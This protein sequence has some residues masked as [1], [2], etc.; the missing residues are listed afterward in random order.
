MMRSN[1]QK[2]IIFFFTLFLYHTNGKAEDLLKEAQTFAH[3]R[4]NYTSNEIQFRI[5]AAI[6]ELSK[7]TYFPRFI[8]INHYIPP[9]EME[10]AMLIGTKNQLYYKND[11]EIKES[12]Y[13]KDIHYALGTI[14]L[15]GPIA[16]ALKLGLG[17]FVNFNNTLPSLPSMEAARG[18]VMTTLMEHHDD[19]AFLSFLD[20]II[21][22]DIKFNMTAD[23]RK[24]ADIKV[25]TNIPE[26]K[27]AISDLQKSFQYEISN[28][29][30]SIQELKKEKH[31]DP[32]KNHGVSI[33]DSGT[34]QDT[35]ARNTTIQRCHD[36]QNRLYELSATAQSIGYII[37]QF[38]PKAGQ[39]FMTKTTGLINV[40][41]GVCSLVTAAASAAPT[42][43]TLI[44][45]AVAATL[46]GVFMLCSS[47]ENEPDPMMELMQQL[48]SEVRDI[49]KMILQTQ[50]MISVMHMDMMNS[51][52]ILIQNDR[53]Q[54]WHLEGIKQT[55]EELKQTALLILATTLA[56]SADRNHK[57][58]QNK[59]TEVLKDQNSLKMDMDC[60]PDDQ[61]TSCKNFLNTLGFFVENTI[62]QAPFML[63]EDSHVIQ[64]LIEQKKY[65][66]IL[67][68]KP[69]NNIN[70]ILFALNA[71][72]RIP[73]DYQAFRWA[74]KLFSNLAT[75]P[76]FMK[77]SQMNRGTKKHVLS[78]I[79]VF[80]KKNEEFEKAT[81]QLLTEDEQILRNWETLMT[82]INADN[83][84]QRRIRST[85]ATRLNQALAILLERSDFSQ[86]EIKEM[87]TLTASKFYRKLQSNVN[88][89]RDIL[90]GQ[91]HPALLEK[92]PR[93]LIVAHN[94]GLMD[95]TYTVS[96]PEW[97]IRNPGMT[98]HNGTQD[99]KYYGDL[100]FRIEIAIV[101]P[102][103]QNKEIREALK[104]IPEKTIFFDNYYVASPQ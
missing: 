61:K 43:P 12:N 73:F 78:I 1:L 44:L 28:L 33:S 93:E 90:D 36:I 68:A 71:N 24:D 35:D 48:L 49:K 85:I 101:K 38:N 87:E 40:A 52:L 84:I 104:D 45:A 75:D 74:W 6:I 63:E 59:K 22:S 47:T 21:P 92:I 96:E 88:I 5:D 80:F 82:T 13:E 100:K 91:L 57:D 26:M 20:K 98:I 31:T 51:F 54:T 99:Y 69:E 27:D 83:A 97:I 18:I 50:K 79:D 2:T 55:I 62:N 15:V 77:P 53:I 102:K 32:Q 70:L 72:T 23:E 76:S 94:L 67:I 19:K 86:E 17:T 16:G 46:Q 9:L 3:Q 4:A 8:D 42:P 34:S 95:I 25:V 56:E 10:I 29:H 30:M 58:I 60:Y 37:S 66:E 41:M 81:S 7:S 11:V 14:P 103:T 89:H 65:R 64:T 39:A